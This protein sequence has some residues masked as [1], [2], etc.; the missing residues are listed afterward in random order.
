MEWPAHLG[1]LPYRPYGKKLPSERILIETL[2]PDEVR[3]EG[4]DLPV[5]I[6]V[7]NL[8]LRNPDIPEMGFIKET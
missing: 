3:Q 7:G 5:E 8:V 6:R 2:S 4:L 1:E